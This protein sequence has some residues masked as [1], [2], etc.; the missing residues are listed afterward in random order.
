MSLNPVTIRR[1]RVLDGVY[2]SF[3]LLEH[4]YT[5]MYQACA[6]ISTDRTQLIA[7]LA[8]C[9]GFI[10]VL[11][12]LRELAQTIPGLSGKNPERERFLEHTDLAE[13]YRHYIQHL[14]E[15][16]GAIQPKP[17]PVWG[18]LSWVD[19][20]DPELSHTV[21]IGAHL[22]NSTYTSAVYDSVER[23]WVSRVTLGVGET[24]FNFDPIFEEAMVFEKFVIPWMIAQDTDVLTISSDLPIFSMRF[25]IGNRA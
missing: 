20:H 4:H 1:I 3:R 9:W 7:A 24:S 2:F 10:D 12:R 11:H 16:L 6:A 25:G 21:M 23:R 8:S 14:R 17:S 22:P 15:E 13:T 18:S 19:Q 5:A